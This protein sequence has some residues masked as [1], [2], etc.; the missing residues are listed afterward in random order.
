MRTRTSVPH[1]GAQSK[2]ISRE[3]YNIFHFW[4]GETLPHEC[5]IR[6]GIFHEL[7]K[8]KYGTS[9]SGG[10]TWETCYLIWDLP[11]GFHDILL[12]L[13]I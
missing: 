4:E 3:A 8:K 2:K 12:T 11:P 7:V 1:D 13:S 5:V 10:V 9:N 6:S